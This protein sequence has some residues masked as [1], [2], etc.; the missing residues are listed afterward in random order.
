MDIIALEDIEAL[1]QQVVDVVL[2]LLVAT[3]HFPQRALK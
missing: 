3:Q 2:A 1:L